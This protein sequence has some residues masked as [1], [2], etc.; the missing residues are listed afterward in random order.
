MLKNIDEA[1]LIT[2]YDKFVAPWSIK[3]IAALLIFF[4]GHLVAKMIARLIGKV[5]G[6]TKL[7]VILVEF[8]QSLVNALLLVFVVVAALDQLGVNTNS[9]IAVL[10]AAG[11]AIGLALQGSLQNFAAGFMLL[12][13]RPFKGG[14]FV[15]AAGTAGVIDKIG[16]F[17]TTMHTGDNKQVIIPN[18]TIYSSNIINYSARGT[19]RIDMVFSIGYSDDIRLARD[20]IAKVISADARVLPEPEPLIAVGELGASSVNFYVRPWVKSDDFWPVRFDLTEKIKLAFDENGISIP[21][22]QMDIHWNKPG[23]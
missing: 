11:L 4:I 20:V 22:P 14:D 1:Q 19:R 23:E 12:I 6:R 13:F 18:G 10:G 7:D 8:I 16:I 9:V 17:S 5:L 3:I 21:F 2:F 15:E